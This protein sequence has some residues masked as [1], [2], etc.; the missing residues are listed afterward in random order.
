M[1]EHSGFS[2][3]LASNG[4]EFADLR[5]APRPSLTV[6]EG[7]LPYIYLWPVGPRGPAKAGPMLLEIPNHHQ[8]YGLDFG[9]DT[10][11][12][13]IHL[14]EQALRAD[15]AHL[16]KHGSKGLSFVRKWPLI[17]VRFR[18][19]REWNN[20]H[21]VSVELSE[22]Q[23]R[24][25]E[26]L[27]LPV[28]LDPDIYAKGAP[29]DF[30]LM[31]VFVEVC[32]MQNLLA[33]VPSIEIFPHTLCDLNSHSSMPLAAPTGAGPRSIALSAVRATKPR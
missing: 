7:L 10:C 21:G 2:R 1:C 5:L 19:R 16:R 9:K 27:V 12:H 28:S 3:D 14:A 11:V 13:S 33:C 22:H 29:P 20:E 30:P 15:E 23:D 31:D 8:N 26:I 24:S 25:F 32:V 6:H 4:E 18:S 17:R